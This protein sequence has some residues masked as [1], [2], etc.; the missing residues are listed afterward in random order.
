MLN[1]LSSYIKSNSHITAKVELRLIN[2]YKVIYINITIPILQHYFHILKLIHNAFRV[3]WT[4]L[5]CLVKMPFPRPHPR[6]TGL[7][8]LV[9]EAQRSAF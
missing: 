8:N 2:W 1:P 7:E 5:R 3:K 4:Y 6:A 9:G